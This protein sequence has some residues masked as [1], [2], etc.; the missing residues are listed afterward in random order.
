M[1]WLTAFNEF[2]AQPDIDANMNPPAAVGSIQAFEAA[3]AEQERIKRFILPPSYKA[4]LLRYDGGS[5]VDSKAGSYPSLLSID[6]F[7]KPWKSLMS[8]NAADSVLMNH[9]IE[10]Y[11]TF[12]PLVMIGTD[13]GSNFWALDPSQRRTDGEMP[14]RF[15]N[16]ESGDIYAQAD[17]FSAFILLI[18][19][20]RLRYR[21][22]R[23]PVVKGHS[24]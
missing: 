19:D 24:W 23:N 7:K 15:C 6:G 2:L 17:D 12:E 22:L 20:R 10:T 21:G 13:E 18:A 14:V 11:F 4:F 1:D 5:I 3:L 16:H 8:Y 9:E